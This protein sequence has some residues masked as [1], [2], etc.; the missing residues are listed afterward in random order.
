MAQETTYPYTMQEITHRPSIEAET[1]R[2]RALAT[3]A[4]HPEIRRMDIKIASVK[5]PPRYLDERNR[6]LKDVPAQV[7]HCTSRD[8]TLGLSRDEKYDHWTEESPDG[9]TTTT[10][11]AR[12]VIQMSSSTTVAPREDV[13]GE[14]EIITVDQ[15]DSEFVGEKLIE[16]PLPKGQKIPP[17][18][19]EKPKGRGKRIDSLDKPIKTE[20]PSKL[21]RTESPEKKKSESPGRKKTESPE[22]KKPESPKSR[23][24]KLTIKPESPTK[25]KKAE[26]TEKKPSSPITTR[27]EAK[28]VLQSPK[29]KYT[30]ELPQSPGKVTIPS[31]KKPD[32]PTKKKKQPPKAAPKPTKK[33]KEPEV[34]LDE[35]P[36]VK[37]TE[38]TSP[39]KE[40]L[41]G[42]VSQLEVTDLHTDGKQPEQISQTPDSGV[43]PASPKSPEVPIRRPLSPGEKEFTITTRSTKQ[44]P[45]D[46][47]LTEIQEIKTVEYEEPID[48]PATP[49]YVSPEFEHKVLDSRTDTL[50]T[51]RVW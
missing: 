33:V 42:D 47:S 13:A 30:S 24:S 3:Q 28:V 2:K 11:T 21:R 32:S 8:I 46:K 14:T 9:V 7:R 31:D 12:Q 4:Q 37:Q 50:T 10:R 38:I 6:K 22:K 18:V 48:K 44:S 27:Q 40:S 51:T 19:A 15:I 29:S 36:A 39:L 49:T 17:K 34:I 16:K 20:S 26:S 5:T 45:D 41:T 25:G 43:D 23:V 1:P 35:S